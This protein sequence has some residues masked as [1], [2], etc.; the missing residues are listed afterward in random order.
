M[1]GGFENKR[2]VGIMVVL[3]LV[4]AF[5]AMR[6]LGS[7]SAPTPAP[8]ATSAVKSATKTAAKTS[9]ATNAPSARKIGKLRAKGNQ[10]AAT[11]ASLDPTLRFDL[12]KTSEDVEY[13]GGRRNIFTAR[14]E[15]V[16]ETPKGDGTKTGK[17]TPPKP[18]V[19]TGP[20]PLP[21]IDLKFFG[22]ASKPGEPKKVFLS[23]REDVFIASEGEI[24][25]KRYRIVKI[26][27]TSIDVEDVLNNNR[28][29]IPLSQG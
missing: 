10:K 11:I 7:S 8:G 17:N 18:P 22:F 2:E 12:L 16:I 14:S 13:H 9:A 25:N 29:T 1:K 5:T 21:P 19:E 23:Q 28:Q 24:V 27:N 20:P 4:A 26:G 15:P 3:L 6:F